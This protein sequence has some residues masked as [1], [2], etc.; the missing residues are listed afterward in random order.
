MELIYNIKSTI[1][2]RKTVLQVRLAY[3]QILNFRSQILRLPRLPRRSKPKTCPPS[4]LRLVRPHPVIPDLIRD[5]E[6]K[7]YR[8]RRYLNSKLKIQNSK[9]PFPFS[10]F[11]FSLSS[12]RQGQKIPSRIFSRSAP[13]TRCSQPKKQTLFHL[14]QMKD[15]LSPVDYDHGRR[16]TAK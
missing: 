1:Y 16:E 14:F 3:S 2:N 13:S 5:P 12:T 11:I 10:P 15:T 8:H 4:P 7:I 6:L 9:F